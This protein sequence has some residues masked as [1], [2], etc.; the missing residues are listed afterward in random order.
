LKLL[1]LLLILILKQLYLPISELILL[2]LLVSE[3]VLL[4]ISETTYTPPHFRKKFSPEFLS[5]SSPF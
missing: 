5:N 3:L 2:V 1:L 4:L